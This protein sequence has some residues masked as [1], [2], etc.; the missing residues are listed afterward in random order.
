MRFAGAIVIA[1]LLSACGD[2][3]PTP[4]A[5]SAPTSDL[6]AA[7]IAAGIVSDPASAD[8]TGLYARETD[9]LC[10]V[11]DAKDFRVGAFVDYGERQGC[12]GSGTAVRDGDQLHLIFDAAPGCA[13]DARFDGDRIVFPAALPAGCAKLCQGRASFAALDVD[14]LG[15]SPSEARSL[16]NPRGKL[17]CG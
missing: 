12:S 6:E 4:K 13:F 14:R 15:D 3:E 2:A 7:A 10:I 5:G 11:P 1:A 9:K 8:L 16:R 17:L